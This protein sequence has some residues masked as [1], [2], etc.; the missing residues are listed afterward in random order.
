MQASQKFA[1]DVAFILLSFNIGCSSKPKGFSWYKSW[2]EFRVVLNLCL[3]NM[4]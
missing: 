1:L 2:V 3:N 4:L